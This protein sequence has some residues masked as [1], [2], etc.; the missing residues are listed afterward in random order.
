MGM[1][2]VRNRGLLKVVEFDKVT[3]TTFTVL[4]ILKL[5]LHVLYA[6]IW[7]GKQSNRQ[8]AKMA[9]SFFPF[10]PFKKYSD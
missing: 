1:S 5:H 2:G 3:A 4:V 7:M 9:E 6:W 8:M 10:D